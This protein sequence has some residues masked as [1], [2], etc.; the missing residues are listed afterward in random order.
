MN[1]N[2]FKELKIEVYLPANHLE[3]VRIALLNAG[4]GIV[5]NYD[6]VFST[7]AVTGHWRPLD[8]ANPFQ[9]KLGEIEIASEIKLEVNCDRKR[10]SAVLKAIRTAHPYEEPL[11]RVIPILNQ[12][13]E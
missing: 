3:A 10:V 12:F 9:G 7:T 13:F 4:A 11:I 8:G 6:N 2:D 5:G 1:I